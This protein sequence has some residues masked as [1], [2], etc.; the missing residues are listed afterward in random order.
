MRKADLVAALAHIPD[1]EDVVIVVIA[2]PGEAA[3]DGDVLRISDVGFTTGLH[4][5]RAE[6]P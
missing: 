4:V 2:E 3:E 1:D 6:L 5:I